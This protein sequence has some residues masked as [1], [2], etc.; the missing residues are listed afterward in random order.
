[1]YASDIAS[2]LENPCIMFADDINLFEKV[3]PSRGIWMRFT[4]MVRRGLPVKLGK[5]QWLI[6]GEEN[7]LRHML[8]PRLQVA[9]E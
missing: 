3:M 7:P 6:K 4:N 8:L 5:C 2:S 1:M 9:M